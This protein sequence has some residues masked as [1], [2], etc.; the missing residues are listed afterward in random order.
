MDRE[1]VINSVERRLKETGPNFVF[2]VLRAGVRQDGDWWYVP[3]AAS[4]RTG[5]P[6]PREF[7]VSTFANVEDAI[8]SDEGASVLFIPFTPD[9]VTPRPS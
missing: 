9:P 5:K 6:L 2:E 3:V 1:A 8:L 7:I 4:H